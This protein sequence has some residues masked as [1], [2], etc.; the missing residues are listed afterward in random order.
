MSEK[1]LYAIIFGAV[2]GAAAVVAVVRHVRNSD[3]KTSDDAV[4]DISD[5]IKKAKDT[6][7]LLD[8]AVDSLSRSAT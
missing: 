5:I 6:I 3:S 4:Q 7:N 1:K 2:V 8:T